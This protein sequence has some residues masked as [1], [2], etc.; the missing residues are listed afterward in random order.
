MTVDGKKQAAIKRSIDAAAMKMD[1]SKL[2]ATDADPKIICY[3]GRIKELVVGLRRV[4]D[5]SKMGKVTLDVK[6]SGKGNV[7]TWNA[8]EFPHQEALRPPDKK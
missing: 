3:D 2:P 6:F 7:W 1:I 8:L 5:A 4:E